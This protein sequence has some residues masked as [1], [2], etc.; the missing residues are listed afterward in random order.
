MSG[1]PTAEHAQAE[2]AAA[3]ALD[4]LDAPERSAFEAHLLG[5]PTCRAE[6]EAMREV[7]ASLAYGA[8]AEVPPAELRERV[9]ADARAAR[10]A[11]REAVE[12][13]GMPPTRAAAGDVVPLRR[14]LRSTLVPWLAF[15]AALMLAA[16]LAFKVGRER[17]AR[18]VAERYQADAEQRAAEAVGQAASRDSLLRLVLSPATATARLA[19]TGREPSMQLVWNRTARVLVVSAADLR[20][21]PAG[22]TYQL[23]GLTADGTPR[24]LGTFD[25]EPAGGGFVV[26]PTTADA[27]EAVTTSAVTEE[28]AGGSPRPTTTPLLVGRWG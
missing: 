28:P 1:Q 7:A 13:A 6:V 26:L 25:T 14:P 11:Y 17:E 15:A 20:P 8:P 21:A 27:M 22:R 24:S 2:L 23:W 19:A 16:G 4:A 3:Y 10:D 9:L 5:C 12:E 18:H